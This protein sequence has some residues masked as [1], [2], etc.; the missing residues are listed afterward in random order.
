VLIV[1]ADTHQYKQMCRLRTR[2]RADERE[3]EIK[4][5][6]VLLPDRMFQAGI[7]AEENVQNEKLHMRVNIGR[8][9]WCFVRQDLYERDTE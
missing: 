5:R 4:E 9:K 7:C 3:R 2:K 1:I 6:E 8:N